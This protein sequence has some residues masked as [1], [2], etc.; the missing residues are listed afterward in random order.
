MAFTVTLDSKTLVNL[1]QRPAVV[2]KWAK[3]S[4][5]KCP[6]CPV[7]NADAAACP[8]ALSLA[9]VVQGFADVFSFDRVAVR[10]TTPFANLRAA[11]PVGAS[12]AQPIAGSVDGDQRVPHLGE[13]AAA[14]AFSPALRH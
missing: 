12:G 5:Q 6:N 14:D 1:A 8:V 11:R 7:K 10:V 4:F 3:L 13:I 9:G 2:P